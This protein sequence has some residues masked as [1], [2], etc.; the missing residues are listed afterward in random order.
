[1]VRV[2]SRLKSEEMKKFTLSNIRW[3]MRRQNRDD[4]DRDFREIT[5]LRFQGHEAMDNLRKEMDTIGEQ[6]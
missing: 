3:E 2:G 5:R 6:R 1:M 4:L